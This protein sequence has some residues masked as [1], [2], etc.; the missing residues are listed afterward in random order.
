MRCLFKTLQTD[1]MKTGKKKK[2]FMTKYSP[3]RQKTKA[4]VN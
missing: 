4:Q 3:K 2:V 1:L